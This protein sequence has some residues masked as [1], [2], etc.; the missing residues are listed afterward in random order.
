MG[1][2]AFFDTKECE[3]AD[4]SVSIAGAKVAK[5]T[6]VSYET[7]KDKEHLYGAG[8]EPIS[9]QSGNRTYKGSIE[10]FKSAVDAMNAAALAAGGK[11][12]HDLAF[13]IIVTYR[14]QGVRAL[15]TDV[16]VGCEVSSIPKA[17]SQGDKSMKVKLDFL[18]LRLKSV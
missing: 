14:R 9:I 5:L 18:F 15:Q 2:I 17:I 3:W 12:A 6:N 8:D 1:A 16:L 13:D 4:V 10:L 7:G 11:D